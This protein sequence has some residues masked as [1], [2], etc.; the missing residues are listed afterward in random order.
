LEFGI[1]NLK[2]KT[3]IVT[4][5]RNFEKSAKYGLIFTEKNRRRINMKECVLPLRS[6]RLSG[7]NNLPQRREERKVKIYSLAFD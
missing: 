5:N 2:S 1:W 6:S 3:I 7:K 4:F